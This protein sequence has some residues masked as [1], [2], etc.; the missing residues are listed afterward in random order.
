MKTD[1]WV[2][3]AHFVSALPRR[4]NCDKDEVAAR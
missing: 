1:E 3:L 2:S 4:R